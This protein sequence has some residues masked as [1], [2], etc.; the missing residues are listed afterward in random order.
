MGLRRAMTTTAAAVAVT[1]SLLAGSVAVAAFDDVGVIM[2]D[3]CHDGDGSIDACA[4]SLLQSQTAMTQRTF[5][6][7]DGHL[8]PSK[9]SMAVPQ[10]PHYFWPMARGPVGSHS[11]SPYR[12]PGNLS[13]ALAWSYH[14]PDG[15]FSAVSNGAILIDDQKNIYAGFNYAILKFSPSGDLLWSYP[16][17]ERHGTYSDI[18]ALMDGALY[19]TVFAGYIIAIDMESGNLL[20]QSAPVC[21]WQSETKSKAH[22]ACDCHTIGSDIGAVGAHNGVVVVR[23]HQ[24]PGG[25]GAC[26]VAALN[27]SSGTFLW[28]YATEHLVWNFYP[29]INEDEK[30][31]LFQDSAG[32]VYHLGLDGKEIWKAGIEPESFRQTFTD[33]GLQLGPN[34]MVYGVKAKIGANVGPGAVRAF[35]ISD[36]S[37]QWESPEMPYPPNSWPVIGRM[38]PSDPLTVMA[39]FGTAG[40]N[41]DWPNKPLVPG[42]WGLNAETGKV[43]WKWAAPAW[44]PMMF[45]A[46][47][48]RLAAGQ[49]VCLPNPCG[50]PTLDAGGNLYIG[51]L[52]GII[53]ELSRKSAGVG[54]EVSSRFDAGA[55]FSNGGTVIAP[56]MMAILSCDTLFVFKTD[57]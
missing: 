13:S 16:I 23:S 41:Q 46:D 31:F 47:D 18:P 53:Y 11:T 50:N 54:V 19:V 29:M 25:G 42:V 21:T 45:R 56:G 33:G 48:E 55:A 5:A 7:V 39:P 57:A 9:S 30:S 15:K 26:R 44:K 1:A 51:M 49:Q 35:R 36:G 28:D 34:G 24:P 3:H 10:A 22:E 8:Q 12:G 43:I 37:F 14:H 4:T 2:K 6:G 40:M 52:D 27:S 32:G 17:H 38:H 20:W